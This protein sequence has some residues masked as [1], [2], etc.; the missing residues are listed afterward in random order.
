M[1][2]TSTIHAPDVRL[3][4]AFGSNLSTKQMQERCP[5]ARPVRR[6]TIKGWKLVFRG[7]ADMQPGATS[8][9]IHGALYML[10]LEDERQLDRHEG[11]QPGRAKGLYSKVEFRI[12]ATGETAFFYVMNAGH[13]SPPSEEY[14]AVIRRG[15]KDWGLPLA[16]LKLAVEGAK[17]QAERLR[18]K[19]VKVAGRGRGAR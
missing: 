13:V 7:S 1:R 5:S 9:M 17:Q 8:D 15:Y 3:Y 12:N 18:D 4:F 14:R 16:G 10:S 19:G 2:N 11:V 6:L